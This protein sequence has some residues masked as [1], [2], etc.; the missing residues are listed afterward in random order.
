MSVAIH[1]SVAEASVALESTDDTLGNNEAG[2]PVTM[3]L[4][5]KSDTASDD[6]GTTA[7]IAENFVII[8]LPSHYDL[9]T[10]G[11]DVDTDDGGVVTIGTSEITTTEAL[12]NEVED[13]AT[14]D[15]ITVGTFAADSFVTVTITG[16]T[17]P[18]SSSELLV[19]FKQGIVPA[20][21]ADDPMYH[22]TETVYITQSGEGAVTEVVLTSLT[23]EQ[24]TEMS[25]AFD[26][27]EGVEEIV[28][29]LGPGFTVGGGAMLAA[30]QGAVEETA[31]Y[32]DGAFTIENNEFDTG[33]PVMVT[34]TGLTSPDTA[35]AATVTVTQDG[36]AS[37]EGSVI[38]ETTDYDATDA[39]EPGS[40]Q[41][42]RVRGGVVYGSSDNIT[43][44]LEKFTVPGSI[45]VDNVSLNVK[46]MEADPSDVETNGTKVTLTKVTLVAPFETSGTTPVKLY[47]GSSGLTTIT[48]RRSAGI[49]LPP[50]IV[51]V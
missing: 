47:A 35:G 1:P 16:L 20:A 25:F 51:I 12:G 27:I 37:A 23:A 40:N 19:G 41:S 50:A 3:T 5:F 49:T 33:E 32:S 48:F 43:V 39:T 28:V 15:T 17:N 2:V 7:D 9:N 46:G 8:T 18:A 10:D 34:I 42:L 31:S 13:V 29:P 45:D 11:S 26:L 38:I 24:A 4:R 21:T 44:N 30:T 14:G 36:F 22:Q 6:D